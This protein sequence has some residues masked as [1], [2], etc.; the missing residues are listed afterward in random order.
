M[1]EELYTKLAGDNERLFLVDMVHPLSDSDNVIRSPK[2]SP[3][4]ARGLSNGHPP[5]FEP[6]HSVPAKKPHNE[7]SFKDPPNSSVEI[8]KVMV[9][10]PQATVLAPVE[11]DVSADTDAMEGIWNG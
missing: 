10:I 8:K 6:H 3:V 11:A 9:Q 4:D 7:G 2:S 1:R 5:C